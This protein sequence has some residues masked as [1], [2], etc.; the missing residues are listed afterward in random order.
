MSRLLMT[1]HYNNAR[2]RTC[3]RSLTKQTEVKSLRKSIQ[4]AVRGCG[5]I[6]R[7]DKS[8]IEYVVHTTRGPAGIYSCSYAADEISLSNYY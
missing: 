4:P 8:I 7:D 3:H 2:T 1:M 6:I 5:E